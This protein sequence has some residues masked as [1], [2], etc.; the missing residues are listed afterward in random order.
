MRLISIKTLAVFFIFLNLNFSQ[1]AYAEEIPVLS[2]ERGQVQNIVLGQGDSDD[3]WR[4]YLKSTDGRVLEGTKSLTNQANFVVYS[5]S[6]PKNFPISGYVVEAENSNG[7][8]KQVAGIQIIEIQAKEITRAPI[9]LF[10]ILLGLSLYFYF[11]NKSKGTTVNLVS[12]IQTLSNRQTIFNRIPERFKF[13][14]TNESKQSLSKVLLLEEMH[15]DSKYS[16]ATFF[17]GMAGIFLISVLQFQNGFWL[18][19]NSIVLLICFMLGNSSITYG[20]LMSLI[21][22]S[23]LFLN[24]SYA[25]NLGDILSFLIVSSIFILPNFYNRFLMYFLDK[26]H[27]DSDSFE[28][29]KFIGALIASISSYQLLLAFESLNTLILLPNNFKEYLTGSLFGFFI[30]KNFIFCS[31]EVYVEEFNVTRSIGP[32]FSIILGF[33]IS[34]TVY[35]W[36]TNLL[37]SAISGIV[38]LLIFTSNWLNFSI[39]HKLKLTLANSYFILFALIVSILSIYLATQV[40]PLDVINKAHL[41]ILLVFPVDLILAFYLYLAQ[42]PSLRVESQ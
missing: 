37:I 13:Q 10:L 16:T 21:S 12:K 1:V 2:W 35:L 42:P 25:K 11:L 9:E 40:L 22:L 39:P 27:I 20:L 7:Q 17:S 18:T 29:R 8:T 19:G 30:L 26:T 3:N 4:V 23:Y 32:A 38:C 31:F 14:L 34:S 28:I 41:G 33:F 5:I 6:I 15:F 24:I 36:T